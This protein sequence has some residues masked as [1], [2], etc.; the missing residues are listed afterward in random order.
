[1]AEPQDKRGNKPKKLKELYRMVVLEDDTLREVRSSKF[2]IFGL[3]TWIIASILIVAGL[4]FTL[5][6]FTPLRYT[7]PGYADINNNKI[8]VELNEKIE[9][10]EKSLDA[11]KVYTDGFKKFLNP[12]GVSIEKPPSKIENINNFSTKV[13]NNETKSS[14]LSIEHFYFCNPLKG[15][16]SSVFD[17]ESNHYGVDI[18]APAKTP[19]LSIQ[20]GVIINSDWSDKT[21][22]TISVQHKGNL[23]SIFK[24]NSVLLKKTGD[25]VKKGEAIA[26]IGNT[27]E[28][29]SGP[30]VHFELWNN[31][32]AINPTDYLSF[33]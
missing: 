1:M 10:L 33:N 25:H 15:E 20:D 24:H 27:G 16:V 3:I 29:T 31:G 30:H 23:V 19:I 14:T 4:T 2:T 32:K 22:N 11:Q 6:A 7:I 12:S 28:L 26:I 17:I 9:N 18:V 13:A 8:Y 21:G 5:F